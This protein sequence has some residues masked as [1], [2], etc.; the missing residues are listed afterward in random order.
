[1]KNNKGFTLTELLVASAIS[2][3]V[4]GSSMT[5]LFYFFR[6]KT[7]LDT[8]STG[9]IEMSMAIKNLESDLRNVVRVE[10]QEDF[11]SA[12]DSLYFG[13]TDV[14]VGNEPAT[15]LN[16]TNN[17]VIRYTALDRFKRQERTLRTWSEQSDVDQS[18]PAFELR[19]TTDGSDDSLVS[20]KNLP[21]ELVVVDADRRYTRRYEVASRVFHL[22]ATLDPYDDQPKVDSTGS[23]V[24]FNYASLLLKKPSTASS[25]KTSTKQSVFITGSDVYASNT[26]VM[27]LRKSDRSLVKYNTITQEETVLITNNNQEFRLKAFKIGYLN[28]R[29]GTRVDPVNFFSSLIDTPLG[30]CV[31]VI[32]V[33]LSAEVTKGQM[34]AEQKALKSG[35]SRSRTIF[36]TNLNS[37]RA[38]SCTQ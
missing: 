23:A 20:N 9:Q 2:M 22:N 29:P 7:Q 3:I 28:T 30:H 8:W 24:V 5:L 37:R 38:L 16:D 6:E 4:V 17:S 33:T 25:T 26:F 21:K 13:V 19:V 15:C 14:P 11:Q 27:C 36:A 12:G 35:I 18:G 1:M 10:P 31:N 34:D 32:H